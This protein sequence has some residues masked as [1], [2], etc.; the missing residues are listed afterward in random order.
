MG[1]PDSNMEKQIWL[2]RERK[3]KARRNNR[4]RPNLVRRKNEK[5]KKKKEEKE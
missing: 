1:K 5:R 2:I 3:I 4:K